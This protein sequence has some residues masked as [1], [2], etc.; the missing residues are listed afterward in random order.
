MKGYRAGGDG[1][2]FIALQYFLKADETLNPSIAPYFHRL[3]NDYMA[4]YYMDTGDNEKALELMEESLKTF[5]KK[6]EQEEFS[7]LMTLYNLGY[8]HNKLG[9]YEEAV[10]LIQTALEGGLS[11]WIDARTFY[12]MLADSY[13]HLNEIDSARK[14]LNKAFAGEGFE[15]NYSVNEVNFLSTAGN[16]YKA[17]NQYDSAL[18]CYERAINIADSINYSNGSASA[19]EQIIRITLVKSGAAEIESYFDDFIKQRDSLYKRTSFEQ[20]HEY[21]VQYETAKKEAKITVLDKQRKIDRYLIYLGILSFV[22]LL[23]LILFLRMRY[24]AKQLELKQDLHIQQLEKIRMEQQ[25][26]QKEK[27]LANSINNLELKNQTI[28][29]LKKTIQDDKDQQN[30]L[31]AFDQSYISDLEWQKIIHQFNSLYEG[32]LD[33]LNKNTSALSRNDIRLIIL[34]KMDYSNAAIAGIL[35]ISIDGVKKAKQRLKKKVD[36]EDQII[37]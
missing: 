19:I 9:E 12:T 35:N 3:V 32:Y 20:E 6:T 13:V 16:F 29:E 4:S 33:E 15:L 36:L 27:E 7:Y 26:F 34:Q 23:I 11:E 8:I 10:P 22:M 17:Q 37:N 2:H 31:E 21:K 14:Y 18:Y 25:L 24:R 1:K 28:S 5:N 30:I